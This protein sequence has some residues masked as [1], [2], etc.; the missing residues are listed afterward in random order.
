MTRF[1]MMCAVVLVVPLVLGCNPE[2]SGPDT[3]SV[4]GTVYLDDEP[5]GGVEVNFFSSQHDFLATG[6]TGEDGRYELFQG[7]VAG[8][9]KVWIAKMT[10]SDTN[11]DASVDPAE[12]PEADPTQMDAA[13]EGATEE[14]EG[15]ETE[16]G[17]LPEKFS[18]PD[19]T[20]LTFSVPAGGT[21]SADFKLTSE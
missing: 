14:E 5:L 3:V 19:K 2:S 6:A 16:A 9:N 17:A 7:A 13:A 12:N 18:D 15:E 20:I 8:E 4:S 10:A 21:S 1:I 11:P